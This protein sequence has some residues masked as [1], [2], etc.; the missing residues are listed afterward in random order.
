MFDFII[1]AFRHPIDYSSMFNK[2]ILILQ[3]IIRESADIY[4]FIFKPIIPCTWKTGQHSVFYF[5]HTK[6]IG[7]TWRAFSIASAPEEGVIRIA[8]IIKENPSDFKKH[9][10]SLEQGDTLIM[11]GPFGEFHTSEKITQ[12]VGIAGGIGITPF[13]AL[14][15][16][17]A[18]GAIANTKVTLIYSAVGAHT[19]KNEFDQFA[20]NPTIEIIYTSTPE[21]VNQAL[22]A[23]VA[24]HQDSATYFVSGSPGMIG[25][26]RTSLKTKDIKKIVSDPFKGYL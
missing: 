2:R 6:I 3:E 15:K 22:D 11:N 4:S 24:L 26:I 23:Q 19:F 17:I 10:L 16:S 7:K 20:Q 5:P 25:A 9:L 12:I 14:I 18:S 8:T 13:R 21:E 1:R